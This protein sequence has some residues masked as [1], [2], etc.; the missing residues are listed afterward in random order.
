MEVKHNKCAITFGLGTK[1]LASFLSQ[2][3]NCNILAYSFGKF[4]YYIRKST[5]YASITLD[6]Q[7]CQLCSNYASI[8]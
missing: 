8:F 1:L 7:K 5:Y 4:I 3:G 2:V 6:I